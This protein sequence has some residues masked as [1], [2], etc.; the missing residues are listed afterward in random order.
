MGNPSIFDDANA[1]SAGSVAS[2][3]F[4]GH[5]LRHPSVAVEISGNEIAQSGMGADSEC[6]PAPMKVRYG[7]FL[8]MCIGCTKAVKLKQ[9]GLGLYS[10][11][12]RSHL[13]EMRR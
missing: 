4:L 12:P 8:T 9:K 3:D 13:A 2:S 6:P 1:R 7:L 5:A 11:T 10:A